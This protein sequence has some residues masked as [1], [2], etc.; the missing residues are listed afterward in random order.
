[1]SDTSS[2]TMTL[3][4][5]IMCSA[6]AA[7]VFMVVSLP[8]AY[9]QTSK[10]TTTI[11]ETCPTPE[12]KF[13]H[14]ALFFAINYFLMK[15]AAS[16]KYYGM[17]TKSD[18]LIAKYAFTGTLLFFLL[19]STDSYRLTGRLFSGLA[20]ESGCPEVKGVIVHGLVFLVILVLMMY[21]PKDC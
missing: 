6:M 19:S 21:F 1:M 11:S 2:N 14:A 5:K 16:Q 9:T 18:G 8:Q 10:L 13:I 4:K 20:N 17:E 12:G 15:L 3:N 7:I